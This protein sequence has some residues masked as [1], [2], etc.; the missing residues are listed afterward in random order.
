MLSVNEKKEKIKE[1]LKKPKT[2]IIVGGIGVLLLILSSIGGFSKE[3][4][5]EQKLDI[6][7]YRKSVT[8]SVESIVTGITGDK[9]P[10]V[11]ITLESG[12]RYSY[13]DSGETDS[14]STE[15]ANS[16]Q[17]SQSKK[18]TYITV[19]DSSGGE[20]ALVVTESMP[21]IRGVAVV[22]A[23]GDDEGVNEKIKNA[24]QAALDISSKRVFISGGNYN[25]N[26]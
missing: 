25:E 15:G 6:E 14:V 20:K 26:R 4:K 1:Y 8:E 22:C 23:G 24:V 3:S 18:N 17:S 2:L 10:T 5:S 11:V 12:V 16:T 21:Q 7:E 19:R 13:A 9:K